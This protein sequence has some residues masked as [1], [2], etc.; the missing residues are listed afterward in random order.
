[1][2]T[3]E[4]YI[5]YKKKTIRDEAGK[6]AESSYIKSLGRHPKKGEIK[7]YRGTEQYRKAVQDNVEGSELYEK[8][9][10]PSAVENEELIAEYKQY[11][12]AD[13][14]QREAKRQE[15]IRKREVEIKKGVIKE[16]MERI[17]TVDFI[18]ELIDRNMPGLLNDLHSVIDKYLTH[19]KLYVT[20][21]TRY[22][23]WYIKDRDSVPL[24]AKN[25]DVFFDML[26]ENGPEY[27]CEVILEDD[28]CGE[29]D[30]ILE[31]LT[32]H[33]SSVQELSK[34]C[35]GFYDL[36][37][38]LVEEICDCGDHRILKEGCKYME[39]D[40][41][42]SKLRVSPFYKD[43]VREY[44]AMREQKKILEESMLHCIPEN[45]ADLYPFARKFHRKFVLHIGPTNSGKTYSAMQS[46]KEHGS[47]IYLAPLRLL[48]FEQYEKLNS[49][50][51][52]CSLVTG[53]ER[54]IVEGARFQASTIEMMDP[55]TRYEAAVIDEAQ[56]L[57]DNERG[58]AWTAAILGLAASE[59]HV[60]AAPYAENIL[61]QLIEQCGDEYEIVR[62]ERS[63]PLLLEEETFKF[64][65]SVEKGDALILFSRK[66]VHAVASEL[67][68]RGIKCSIL[69][70]S[71][72]YDVRQNEALRFLTGE[73]DVVVS[74]DA[75]GMGLN[76]PIRRVVFLETKK[77][78]GTITR[79]LNVEEI[80]QIA[81]R[82]GRMGMYDAGYVNVWG[83][84]KK[85]VQK[86]LTEEIGDIK[87]AMIDP[88]ETILGLATKVSD[89]LT[90]WEEKE[91]DGM[92]HKA[93]VTRTIDLSLSLDQREDNKELVYYFAQL[94]FDE[95]SEQL[96][97]MWHRLF[98]G[99]DSG[100]PVSDK[101]LL[102]MREVEDSADE[103]QGLEQEYK[104]LDLLYRYAAHY[105]RESAVED[106][107]SR[108]KV[109]SEQIASI[110]SKGR[111]KG[112]KCRM[113]GKKLPWDYPYG[114]CE[115]C[116]RGRWYDRDDYDYD[117]DY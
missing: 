61:I 11:Q 102:A 67:Q 92:L 91:M 16:K 73:T 78:D 12:Q 17:V 38:L 28:F 107:L 115:K 41:V 42:L 49:E 33:D 104:A 31:Y 9:F 18:A 81:G 50:G 75:I 98:N 15:Q 69:Y 14:E 100:D 55:Y 108:K 56:M 90:L 105:G 35:E 52:A 13:L 82:A 96:C 84:G 32:E 21:K 47:G 40:Y 46:L 57:S 10:S 112:K 26:E 24:T 62:H 103:L 64:P 59:I 70:G 116:Y 43:T 83:Q 76:L 114:L 7:R 8:Y 2:L 39:R 94:P 95:K 44:E 86:A 3:I 106:I 25:M 89:I 110:L 88:P 74:T 79:A 71:L 65:G 45:F 72:P 113:C 30:Y 66:N 85:L 34:E 20:T 68:E 22:G 5:E 51:F 23:V 4:E 101:E 53:E 36:N 117:Y 60:C 54:M 1:M 27:L 80:Q 48:A 58:G 87:Y 97:W 29:D 99:E 109:I 77:F 19:E 93:D 37:D 6:K 63:V 111:L